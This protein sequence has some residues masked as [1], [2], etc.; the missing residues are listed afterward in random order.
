MAI[1]IM[2]AAQLFL[3]TLASSPVSSGQQADARRGAER[4]FIYKTITIDKEEY[5]YCVY[6]PVGYELIC[7]S[8]ARVTCPKRAI[9]A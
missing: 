7:V 6:V 1:G 9:S 3:S 8:R 5:A 4:G 2:A